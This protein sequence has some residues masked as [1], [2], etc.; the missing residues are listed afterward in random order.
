MKKTVPL[1][2]LLG[3]QGSTGEGHAMALCVTKNI[4]ANRCGVIF[5]DP[6]YGEYYYNSVETAFGSKGTFNVF[7]FINDKYNSMGL[8]MYYAQF[9]GRF[10]R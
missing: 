4:G 6:N 7:K 8:D 10:G 9:V 5:F 1:I 2:A 3:I